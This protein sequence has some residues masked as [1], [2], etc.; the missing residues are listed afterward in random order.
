MTNAFVHV[1]LN[2]DDVGKAKQF[3]KKMFKWKL[4]DMKMGPGMTY[5][6]VRPDKGTG[7]GMMKKPM[8]EAPTMWLPYV[9][10]DSVSTTIGKARKLGA[11]IMIDEQ[12]IPGAGSFG[13]FLDP[14]GAPL[15]VWQ[16]KAQA[17]ARKTPAKKT[18]KRKN[19]KK[20]A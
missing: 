13:I 6:M 4:E 11:Q 20:R 1:E 9:E 7:G 19:A 10:V 12:E 14:T 17:P 16:S 3:Y 8:P 2:T 18:A 15:G 5:T